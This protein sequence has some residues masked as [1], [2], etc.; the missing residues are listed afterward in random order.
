[1]QDT[2]KE[3]CKRETVYS[4]QLE[5]GFVLCMPDTSEVSICTPNL[6]PQ[7][8]PTHCPLC[9]LRCSNFISLCFVS[10]LSYC[11]RCLL[12]SLRVFL[13]QYT[14]CPTSIFPFFVFLHHSLLLTFLLQ[15]QPVYLPAS[16]QT[17]HFPFPLGLKS[18][19]VSLGLYFC[20]T[21]IT[22]HIR[23]EMHSSGQ[24]PELGEWQKLLC[25]VFTAAHLGKANAWC[26][27]GLAPAWPRWCIQYLTHITEGVCI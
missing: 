18:C 16:T 7:W 20:S 17:L 24:D 4:Y 10:T 23:T 25:A 27:H 26:L 13:H 1:M 19:R 22:L 8:H 9:C 14:K 15:G 3:Q 21:V 5:D 6:S 2:P 11:H 12:S